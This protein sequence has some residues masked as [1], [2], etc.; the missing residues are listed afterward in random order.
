MELYKPI[1]TLFLSLLLWVGAACQSTTAVKDAPISVTHLREDFRILRKTLEEAHPGLYW[2]TSKESMDAY[3]DSTYAQ[4]NQAMPET[5]FLTRLLPVIAHIRCLHTSVRFSDRP[6]GQPNRITRML[7]LMIYL[8]QG[9]VY[10]ERNYSNSRHEGSQL[11]AINKHRVDKLLSQLLQAIPADGYNQTFKEHL[12]AQGLFREGIAIL[13]GQPSQFVLDVQEPSGKTAQCTVPALS[14]VA[15][16]RLAQ[17]QQRSG[18]PKSFD[19]SFPK[20]RT[21]LLTL[22][23]FEVSDRVF[24][25]SIKSVF[26][27]IHQQ[28]T[29]TLIIDVRGNGGGNNQNVAELFS[30]VAQQPFRHLK[31]T[32]LLTKTF[33]YGS[34]I[35]NQVAF[36][37]L[38][39]TRTPAGTYSMNY[40]YAGTVPRKPVDNYGYTGKLIVLANG[41]T[42]SAASEFVALTRGHKRALVVGEETGGCYYGATGGRY[43]EL[44][45]PNSQL[46]IRI[47]AIR[48]FTDVPED[49]A[50]QPKG[51][52]VMPDYAVR[53]TLSDRLA[54]K[55][56][57]L[58]T[59][60]RLASL[61]K[62]KSSTAKD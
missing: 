9:K 32:E 15:L 6:Q 56:S 4:L 22:S 23:T 41:G 21:A 18:S 37:R 47:P 25:D 5:A 1:C 44:M 20:A 29:Q 49:Y 3:F 36:K 27:T 40:L 16:Y 53:F 39:G 13:L 14:P 52:G 60:L 57:Q 2:Y 48:I 7:P 11:L 62:L 50:L 54:H 58:A 61:I 42:V 26:R 17:D 45:L 51:R 43:L 34:H 35:K 24:Q 55:D 38:R 46:Q 59:A 10:I 30:Y 12:L 8:D 33:T 19:L 28:K 31:K